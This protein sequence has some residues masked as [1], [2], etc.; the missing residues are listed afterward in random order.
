M[1][2]RIWTVAAALAIVAAIVAVPAAYA[3]YTTAKLEVRRADDR[4][5]IVRRR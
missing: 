3:A 5:V 1:K 2:R 4:R